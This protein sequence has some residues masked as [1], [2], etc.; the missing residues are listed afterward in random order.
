M[1]VCCVVYS[2]SDQNLDAILADPPLVWQVVEP[3]D[4]SSYLKALQ[5]AARP[6]F[7]GRLLGRVPAPA[8][9]RTLPL[10]GPQRRFVDLDKSW[11]GLNRVLATLAPSAPAFFD[12]PTCPG[13]IEVGYGPAMYQHSDVVSEVATAWAALTQA[14]LRRALATTD[15]SGAYLE[16]VWK[17]RDDEALEYLSENFAGLQAFLALAQKHQLGAL[18]QMT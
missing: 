9:P 4:D 8:Q 5:A 11:D 2:I 6:S 7:M 3:D 10:D 18:L 14:D 16:G 13:G 1:G 12:A 17:Q 15:F